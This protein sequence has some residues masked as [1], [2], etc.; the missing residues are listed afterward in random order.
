[1][2][3]S[4]LE[5]LFW[6]CVFFILYAYI[7]YPILLFLLKPF[8]PKKQPPQLQP[9]PKVSIVIA[10]YNEEKTIARRVENCLALDYPGDSLEIIIASDGSTD[11]TNS[12]VQKFSPSLTLP[13]TQDKVFSGCGGE[14]VVLYDYPQR[15]GKVNVLNDTVPKAHHDIIV[16][17]D[18]NTIFER[19][20]V[21]NLVRHFKD[22]RVGCVCGQLNF[23][24]AQ[25]S[26]TGELEGVYWKFETWLKKEEGARGSLLGANGG[27]FALRKELFVQCPPGTIVEDF[28]IA[29]KI[30]QRGYKVIYDPL[31]RATEE[32][33]SNIIHEK[34][35]RVR[36]GAGDFQA[37]F[38]LLP[39]LSPL[40]G[41]SALAFW[42]HKV[43]RWFVPFFMVGAFVANLALI[44]IPVYRLLF[45]GQIL[46]YLCALFGQILNWSGVHSK[47]FNLCYY[48]VSMNSAL[49]LGFFRFLFKTQK[50]T[51]E[52]TQ[53]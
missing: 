46:F 50:V 11:Q 19:D 12:L 24:N 4:F 30:L 41:F 44:G 53:R 32:S 18:A 28:V 6:T 42:S 45:I 7:F 38:M 2:T 13:H 15:R 29:M 17:S 39:M 49:L 47:F 35:R 25:G 14:K 36:I 43:I 20:A 23:V 37:L 22:E 9:W 8:S 21:K 48:F 52:R 34:K 5:I 16:F 27:I 3:F 1:M 40:R 31:A 51:W 26:R 33:A 10:A